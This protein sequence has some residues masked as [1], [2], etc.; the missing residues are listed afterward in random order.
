MI[1]QYQPI[2]MIVA[3]I[4]TLYDLNRIDSARIN[5]LFIHAY[6]QQVKQL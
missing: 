3:Q 4:K 6:E 2:S 5:S 1:K